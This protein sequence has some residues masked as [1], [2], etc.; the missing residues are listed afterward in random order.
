MN[1][2]DPNF[3]GEI[4]PMSA[5]ERGRLRA[6]RKNSQRLQAKLDRDGATRVPTRDEKTA[7]AAK[8]AKLLKVAI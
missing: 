6:A 8:T 2:F 7:A 3:K 5:T 1:A 4:A